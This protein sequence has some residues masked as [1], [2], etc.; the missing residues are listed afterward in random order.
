MKTSNKETT[1]DTIEAGK[2]FILP[3]V[4]ICR[5]VNNM[6]ATERGGKVRVVYPNDS[7]EVFTHKK[8]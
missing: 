6:T 5:K 8:S 7:V 1:F 3:Q 2:L 4:G